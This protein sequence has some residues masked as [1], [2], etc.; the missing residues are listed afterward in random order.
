MER[1]CKLPMTLPYEGDRTEVFVRMKDDCH[2]ECP[3][4]AGCIE[5]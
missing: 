3:A 1:Y 2:P 4:T 5:G